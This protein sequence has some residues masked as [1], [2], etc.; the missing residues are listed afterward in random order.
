[1]RRRREKEE[2]GWGGGGWQKSKSERISKNKERSEKETEEVDTNFWEKGKRK[3]LE[4]LARTKEEGERES[5]EVDTNFPNPICS[6]FWLWRVAMSY[7]RP[8]SSLFVCGDHKATRH[9]NVITDSD[10]AVKKMEKETEGKEGKKKAKKRK[11][12]KTEGKW[13]AKRHA[14]LIAHTDCFRLTGHTTPDQLHMSIFHFP[15]F[16]SPLSVHSHQC[17]YGW[18]SATYP[19]LLLLLFVDL[20]LPSILLPSFCPFTSIL[21]GWISA[22][23]PCLLL[24]LLFVQFFLVSD[25]AVAPPLQLTHGFP[26]ARASV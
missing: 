10:N 7:A 8:T 14:S 6:C 11:K 15:R 9:W 20:P 1:L 25:P 2:G 18:I 24:L 17:V 3:G 23:Y 16:F 26:Q 19:C 13:T 5:E 21:I 22:T 12:K 4:E